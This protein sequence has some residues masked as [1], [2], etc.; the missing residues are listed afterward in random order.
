MNGIRQF[1]VDMHCHLDLYPDYEAA[2]AECDR[3]RVFTIAVTTTPRAWPRNLELARRTRHVRAA[4]GIHPQLVADITDREL[5]LWERYLDQTHYIGEVGLDASPRY[6][7]SFARQK[8]VFETVLRR[9]ASHGN[10]LLT[11]HAVRTVGIALDMIEQMLP[12][13]RGRVVL[14]WF[15]GKVGEIQRATA[16]GCYFSVN[17]EM[18]Q[19]E[20][21]RNIATNIPLERLLTETDGPFT[22]I[23]NRPMQ[24]ADIGSTL[25]TLAQLRG[26]S[27]PDL[28]GV[29]QENLFELAKFVDPSEPLLRMRS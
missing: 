14:H 17:S 16:L 22:S 12:T 2:F 6:Y 26:L 20:Y 28:A 11:V 9:C 5:D 25:E 10:K 13:D 21:G 27:V 24:P 18:L 8:E 23:K 7:P 29:V 3:Q 15:S 1:M 4:L 19:G